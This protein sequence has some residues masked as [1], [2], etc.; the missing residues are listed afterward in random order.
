VISLGWAVFLSWAFVL[1]A[2]LESVKRHEL[3]DTL[4]RPASHTDVP[5][6]K[7]RRLLTAKQAAERLGVAPDTIWDWRQSKRLRHR[8]I[9]RMIRI[10]PQALED[11]ERQ[12]TIE[13]HR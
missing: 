7:S 10:D 11:F 3:S 1:S 12:R 9:G 2:S 8:K 4:P 5:E 6:S 13:P